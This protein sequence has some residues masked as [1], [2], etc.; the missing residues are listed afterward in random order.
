MD[1]IFDSGVFV[2][3]E[4]VVCFC[5]GVCFDVVVCFGNGVCFG[6]VILFGVVV[7]FDGG[8]EFV[9][10][11]G[12]VLLFGV[13]FLMVVVKG[14]S[15][16]CVFLGFVI[17]VCGWDM[18]I[19][20]F[21]FNNIVFVFVIEL[22]LLLVVEIELFGVDIKGVDLVDRVVVDMVVD[23]VKEERGEDD[24]VIEVGNEEINVVDDVWIDEEDFSNKNDDDLVIGG[25]DVD[26]D[27]WFD[28]WMGE[29]GVL[30]D[31]FLLDGGDEVDD[32][33][34]LVF[35]FKWLLKFEWFLN[36]ICNIMKIC[37]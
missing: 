20:M 23:D 13:V 30:C 31:K 4:D 27:E 9:R 36:F 10:I 26:S 14:V 24:D 17:L 1:V 19:V 11:L 34:L 25:L 6:V 15:V 21:D 28:D 33:F 18:V 7:C 35:F 3:F 8:I 5:S 37:I 29:V 16:E 22:V 32:N 12:F 2:C